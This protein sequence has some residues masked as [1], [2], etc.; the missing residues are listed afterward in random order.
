MNRRTVFALTLVLIPA[1]GMA[2]EKVLDRMTA[3]GREGRPL[4]VHVVVALCD[5]K[6]QGIVPVPD[7][8]GNGQN[9][10]SNLYWGAGGGVKTFLTR[11]AGWRMIQS[12][13]GNRDGVL[14]SL[15]LHQK[16]PGIGA[17][18]DVYLLAEAWD[19]REINRA[20]ARFFTLAGGA[21]PETVQLDGLESGVSIQAGGAALL[22]VYVGHDGLMETPLAV[23]PR[24]NPEA[25]P[26]G[27]VVLA[28]ASEMFFGDPLRG[29]G[30]FPLVMTTGLMAPEAYTLDAIIK[31]AS[32]GER[33]T[34]V[35]KAAAQAYQQYQKCGIKA[36]E[37]LFNGGPD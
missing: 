4:V 34:N 9:P 35:R 18:R 24:A 26:R 3:E 8:L 29:T 27:A 6:Y 25:K 2:W 14:E 31:A 32:R 23:A 33:P 13:K 22:I 20:I 15:V 36:A 21:E 1:L 37:R 12:R 7:S 17:T 30:A 11:K 19:G 16:L 10:S 28:C 5:N